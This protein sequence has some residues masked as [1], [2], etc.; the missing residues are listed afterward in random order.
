[1]TPMVDPR[2]RVARKVRGAPPWLRFG[3]GGIL[4]LGLLTLIG[5]QPYTDFLWFVH[6]VRHPEVF[7]LALSTEGTL[8]A[9][10]FVL[11]LLLFYFSFTKALGVTMV[12]FREPATVGEAVIANAIRW[13][14]QHGHTV[15]K[16]AA[17]A[18]AFLGAVGFAT[19]W[20]TWLLARNVQSFG[21]KDPAFGL[22]VGFFVFQLPWYT[23]IANFAFSAFLLA[24][25]G[26]FGVYFGLEFLAS[27][28]KIEVSK[29]FVR[30]HL[31]LLGVGLLLSG[32]AR[33]WLGRY[34]IGYVENAL[35]T[36]GGYAEQMKLGVQA[37]VA[38]LLLPLAV[39][40]LINVN[41]G[42]PW[43][44]ALYGGGAWAVIYVLGMAVYPTIVQR[45]TVEPNKIEVESPFAQRAM[46]MTR[47]AYGLEGLDDKNI[48]VS[49]TPTAEEV[50][51]SGPTL[52]NMRLWDPEVLR[53]SI[54]PIQSLRAFYKFHDVDVDRYDI[55]GKQR[56]VMLAPR[57][58]DLGGLTPGA[59]NWVNMRLQYTHGYGLTMSAVNEATRVGRPEFLIRDFPP[60]TPPSLPIERPQIY[61]SDARDDLGLPDD[62]YAI[63]GTAVKEF[64]YPSESDAVYNR[65]EEPRGVPVGGLMARIAY[66]IRNGDGNLLVSG[67]IMSQ[68]RILFRRNVRDRA[69][70]VYP[71]LRFDQDP[72]LVVFG[73][74]LI[75][76]LDGYTVSDRVPYS[77]ILE[78]REGRL[79]YIR[80][81]VKVTID[82]Y[83]GDMHA[84]AVL[85]DDPVLKAYRRIYPRL[86]EDRTAVPKGLDEHFRYP[87]DLFMLQA[88]QL[89][90]Y[91]VKTPTSFLNNDDAWDLPFERGATGNSVRMAAYYV[92]LQ[93]PDDPQD[94]FYLILPMTPRTKG[95]MSGWLAA[96]CDPEHYGKLVLYRYPKNSNTPGPAQME[97]RFNQDQEIA[98]LNKLL[99]SDESQIVQGN[100]L[101]IPLGRSVLYVKPLFLRSRSQGIAP[102]PELRK[103]ILA[104]SS[105]IVVAD[106]YDEALS[107][108]FGKGSPKPPTIAAP[109]TPSREPTPEAGSAAIKAELKSLLDLLNRA[110]EALRGGDFAKYGE[111]QKEARAKLEALSK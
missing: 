74:R 93:L 76:I 110:D 70:Q 89:T 97:S 19:E 73:G 42:K 50:A 77:A 7:T 15:V 72:Y 34:E 26:T 49:D 14:Q 27:M 22:D 95:N 96:H 63:V 104:T 55:D 66:S 58:I 61:F 32:A 45:F 56:L 11:E 48:E 64:D 21:V 88:A 62:Q 39:A 108:L 68:S 28:A 103:V 31:T 102:I 91:H 24:L 86:V 25:A 52:A 79:N 8:F 33:L 80:N 1:M 54:E 10:A 83:S 85:P 59:R 106:T 60:K 99:N 23:A 57:D 13:I 20:N 44:V 29:P 98:N 18:F 109:P 51:R 3:L 87:E 105:R 36:G 40:L 4:L 17:V 107:E 100:L 9:I 69:Q 84:Y 16:V 78:T 92:Q 90:Q 94:R 6:D 47:F 38:I 53:E 82:A 5:V 35:F 30:L 65:W 37:V 111:L 81:S 67:N 43:R 101:V 75:W 46:D 71:F 41:R 2:L 12:Y